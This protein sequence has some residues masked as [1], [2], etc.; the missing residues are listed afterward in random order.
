MVGP[1]TPAALDAALA[2]VTSARLGVVVTPTIAGGRLASDDEVAVGFAVHGAGFEAGAEFVAPTVHPE[3]RRLARR[4]TNEK[5]ERRRAL[6]FK[7][8]G[9][10][11]L[12]DPAPVPALIRLALAAG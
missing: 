7:T 2:G 5:V 10:E 9:L 11:P 6:Y 4:T 8:R 3:L 12:V 1:M